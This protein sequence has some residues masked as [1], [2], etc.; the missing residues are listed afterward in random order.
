MKKTAVTLYL[1][2]KN[3]VLDYKLKG[4]LMELIQPVFGAVM[5]HYEG[6]LV[7]A[8]TEIK[9][10]SNNQSYSISF[11]DGLVAKRL[12]ARLE[13]KTSILI[14]LLVYEDKPLATIINWAN[15]LEISLNQVDGEYQCHLKSSEAALLALPQLT[16]AWSGALAK[17]TLSTTASSGAFGHTITLTGT[18]LHHVDAIF[19]DTEWVPILKYN[20]DSLEIWMPP[21]S[22][23]R[24]QLLLCNQAG[25]AFTNQ[26]YERQ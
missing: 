17:G 26:Y 15:P 24:H 4:N 11:P 10:K 6:I 12:Q 1:A 20:Q 25:K 22:R 16:Y 3:D 5:Y 2:D 23:K 13:K 19:F 18:D 14:G 8:K 7:E 21:G 9:A